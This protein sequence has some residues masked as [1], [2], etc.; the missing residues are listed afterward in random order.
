LCKLPF[1]NYP[2]DKPRHQNYRRTNGID[3]RQFA[4]TTLRVSPR[5]QIKVLYILAC[6]WNAIWLTGRVFGKGAYHHI[7]WSILFLL[8]PPL[9]LYLA[10][11][12]TFRERQYLSEH[13]F[14]FY[15]AIGLAFVPF[16]GFC[17]LIILLRP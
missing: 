7:I 4:M 8:I 11:R 16:I 5:L 15:G 10:V 1:I 6:I 13:P 14:A 9:F 3:N 12:L 2:L 17:I